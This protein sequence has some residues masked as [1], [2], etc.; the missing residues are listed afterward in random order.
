[1]TAAMKIS[2]GLHS[3]CEAQPTMSY[4]PCRLQSILS[5]LPWPCASMSCTEQ[6][7][8][9]SSRGQLAVASRDAR[10]LRLI[11]RLFVAVDQRDHAGHSQHADHQQRITCCVQL[12]KDVQ[13]YPDAGTT[14]GPAQGG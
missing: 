5:C 1:M 13:Q 9:G 6:S 8:S 12:S 11:W 7:C 10:H 14:L 3:S 2:A 4:V